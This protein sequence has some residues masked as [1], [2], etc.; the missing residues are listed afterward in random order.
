[1]EAFVGVVAVT[2]NDGLGDFLY[3][4]AGLGKSD[5]RFEP[6][7]NL[8]TVVASIIR[9][10]ILGSEHLRSPQFGRQR[11]IKA[12]RHYANDLAGSAV[13]YELLA[14]DLRIGAESPLPKAVPENQN[15]VASLLR[16]IGSE[17]TPEHRANSQNREHAGGNDSAFD[18]LRISAHTKIDGSAAEHGNIRKTAVQ[19]AEVAKLRRGKPHLVARQANSGEPPP[20]FYESFRIRIRQWFQQNGVDDAE[21]GAVGSDTQCKRDHRDQS[22]PRIPDQPANRIADILP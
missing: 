18:A 11:I 8:K 13:E 20:D 16:F 2:L 21:D 3:I 6:R 10:K 4:F 9:S 22:E 1:M 12:P 17:G 5:P 15:T 7:Q 19:V 14:D